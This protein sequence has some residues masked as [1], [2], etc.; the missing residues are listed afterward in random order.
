MF[1]LMFRALDHTTKNIYRSKLAQMVSP[2]LW[3]GLREV[4]V[5]SARGGAGGGGVS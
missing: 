5:L 2:P 1:A 4:L 3:E